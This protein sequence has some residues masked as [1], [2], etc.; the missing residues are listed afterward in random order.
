MLA[1]KLIFTWANLM[2]ASGIHRVT[3]LMNRARR[4]VSFGC[5]IDSHLAQTVMLNAK[6]IQS[7][8]LYFVALC[9]QKEPSGSSAL[10]ATALWFLGISHFQCTY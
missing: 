10:G 1:H 7:V 3:A 6:H 9:A 5:Q 4:C 8:Y 2:F